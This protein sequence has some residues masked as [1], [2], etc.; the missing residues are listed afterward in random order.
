MKV[1]SFSAFLGVTFVETGMLLL[2]FYFSSGVTESR[3]LMMGNFL[4]SKI[5]ADIFSLQKS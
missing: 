3:S 5:C 4:E 2:Y 1:A